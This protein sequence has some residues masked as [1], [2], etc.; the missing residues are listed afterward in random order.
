MSQN[1]NEKQKAGKKQQ[2]KKQQQKKKTRKN[3][4]NTLTNMQ[5]KKSSFLGKTSWKKQTVDQLF[6]CSER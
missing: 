6:G 2:A 3:K 5:N 4:G 1:E